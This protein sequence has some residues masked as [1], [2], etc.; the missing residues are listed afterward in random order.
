MVN[1][2]IENDDVALIEGVRSRIIAAMAAQQI[3][4]APL[5]KR[6]GLNESAV[7]DILRGRSLNPGIVTMRKIADALEVRPGWLAFGEGDAHDSHD[8]HSPE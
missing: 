4:A 6:A 3:R 2:V 7:R 1:D 5:A 8:S